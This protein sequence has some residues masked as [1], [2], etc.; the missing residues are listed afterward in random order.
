M[1]KKDQLNTVQFTVAGQT[2]NV[3][4]PY[5]EGHVL[6]AAEASVLNQTYRE[7]VR[8]G[9]AP[10]VK[11]H[12][13]DAQAILNEF[14]EN[15]SFGERRARVQLN[16]VDSE[17]K[18]IAVKLVAQALSEKGIK[19][20]DYEKYDEVVAKTMIRPDVQESARNIVDQQNQV[21]GGAELE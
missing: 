8:N 17:A 12:P 9:I 5:T 16:P 18:K 7:N 1:A 10:K 2:L 4:E 15:Y 13:A 19:K 6:N 21:T 20:A 14:V 11:E 3:P